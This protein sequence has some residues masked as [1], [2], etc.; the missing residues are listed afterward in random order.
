MVSKIEFIEY[1]IYISGKFL[2]NLIIKAREKAF[3]ICLLVC[4]KVEEQKLFFFFELDETA[5]HPKNESSWKTD[6]YVFF[7][8]V[9]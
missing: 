6:D 3:C 2:E 9:I 7:I 8:L 1:K 4:F 5:P